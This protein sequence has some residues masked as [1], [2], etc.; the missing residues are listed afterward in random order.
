MAVIHGKHVRWHTGL[1]AASSHHHSSDSSSSYNLTF[2]EENAIRYLAG[3]VVRKLELKFSRRS[4]QEA[5]E[6]IRVLKD[7][8]GKLKSRETISEHPSTEWTKLIDQG[9][10][11]HIDDLVYD[12]F[13]GIE[14][15]ANDKL[16]AIFNS[17]GKGIEQVKKEKLA[18]LCND[19]DVQFL[20]CMISPTTIEEES[21]RQDLLREIVHLWITA[22]GHSKAHAV[23]EKYKRT[24]GKTVNKKHS[25]RK[26]L[27][28][29]RENTI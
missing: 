25:L 5:A 8:G 24:K 3:Y 21:V 12:L 9:G 4:T 23:K 15:L 1:P 2:I 14:R 6:C 16:S 18:W 11:Y 10:L 22:R 13:V 28:Q 29:A 20:W 27:Q 26:E 17:K 19:E 7:M